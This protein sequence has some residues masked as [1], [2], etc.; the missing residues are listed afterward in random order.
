MRSLLFALTVA[1]CAVGVLSPP[2]QASSIHHNSVSFNGVVVPNK[3]HLV[4]LP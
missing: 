3:T 1:A 4:P 2:A